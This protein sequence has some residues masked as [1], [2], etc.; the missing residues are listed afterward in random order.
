MSESSNAGGEFPPGTLD[1]IDVSR[2]VIEQTRGA[3]IMRPEEFLPS[4]AMIAVGIGFAALTRGGWVIFEENDH[5]GTKP[6][7]VADAEKLALR[8]PEHEWC[9]HLVG[10]HQ[11]RHYKRVDAGLWKLYRWGAGLAGLG[12]RPVPRRRFTQERLRG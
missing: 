5:A 7:T 11:E 8:S 4:E 12:N 10:T 3:W 2:G 9:I 6:M 1:P